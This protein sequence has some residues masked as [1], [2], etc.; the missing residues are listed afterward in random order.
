M[1]AQKSI[2]KI[3]LDFLGPDLQIKSSDKSTPSIPLVQKLHW[4]SENHSNDDEGHISIIQPQHK[5]RFPL[6]EHPLKLEYLRNYDLFVCFNPGFGSEPLKMKWEETLKLLLWTR[7]PIV[8]TAHGHFDLL[9]DLDM[10]KKVSGEQDSE[11]QDL[12]EPI[13][14]MFP[15]HD[16]P[17]RSLKATVDKNEHPKARIIHNNHSIYAFVSK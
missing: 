17:F 9:R 14:F 7:K 4:R 5:N 15:H 2:S 12:G 3:V 16:N 11:E 6:H 8:C 10:I 1:R 13:E